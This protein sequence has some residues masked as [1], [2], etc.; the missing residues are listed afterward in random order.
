MSKMFEVDHWFKWRARADVAAAVVLWLAVVTGLYLAFQ[1]FTTRM[2][3]LNFITFGPVTLFGLGVLI[4]A[5]FIVKQGKSMLHIGVTLRYALISII[6]G[7]VLSV[8][9]YTF[10]LANVNLPPMLNLIPLV[11]MTLTVG[12]FEAVFFRG[13]IQ[14]RLED[15]FGI[16]PGIIVASAM[17]ALYHIGYGMSWSEMGFLFFLGLIFATIFRITKNILIL[18]PFFSPMGSLYTNIQ[19]GL[20]LPFEATYGFIIVLVLMLATL[21][22]LA[23]KTKSHAKNES[24][25]QTP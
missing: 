15:S 6:I 14:L 2:V 17:Y 4:P 3:A 13:F 23:A 8:F 12:L 10:T 16:I 1:V 5:V 7:L 24:R 21:A 22:V 9:Q 11:T 19:E 20:L 25:G 18:W